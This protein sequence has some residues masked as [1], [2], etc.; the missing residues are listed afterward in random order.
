MSDY[1]DIRSISPDLSTEALLRHLITEKFPGK[2]VVT[3]SLKARSI[4]VLKMVS[5]INPGIAVRFCAPG[6]RF[7]ESDAYQDSIVARLGLIDVEL[8]RGGETEVLPGDLSHYEKMWVEYRDSPGRNL[9][10]VHLNQ[11]LA[12]FD[13]WI[14]AV[15]HEPSPPEVTNRVGVESRLIRVDPLIRWSKQEVR[16]FLKEQ[17]LPLHPRATR[18]PPSPPPDDEPIPSYSY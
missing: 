3:A 5:D 7:P 15:Y 12:P 11:T 16:A 9:E 10:I 4:A 8:V 13:C 18:Q 6:F 14:S 1:R 2:T 17:G